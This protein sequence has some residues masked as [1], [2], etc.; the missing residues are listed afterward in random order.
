MAS[1]HSRQSHLVALEGRQIVFCHS[2]E[3]EW[4]HEE[5]GLKCP[6]CSSEATEI[7]EPESD[8]RPV[9]RDLPSSFANAF[10]N[11]NRPPGIDSD[12]DPEEGDIEEHAIGGPGGLFLRAAA[13]RP[14][15]NANRSPEDDIMRRFTELL[16]DLGGP[17]PGYGD[18]AGRSPRTGNRPGQVLFTTPPRIHRTTFHA[19]PVSGTSFTITTGTTHTAG[20]PEG[21]APPD[22]AA[23]FGNLIRPPSPNANDPSRNTPG[24][25]PPF[26]GVFGM[27]FAEIIA[28]LINPQQA[29]RGDAVYTQE[30]LDR[31]ITTLMEANPQS[32]AAPPA[33]QDAIENLEKKRL[34]DEMLGPEGKAECTICIDDMYKGAEVS[35]LPCKHWFHGE[36][37]TLW[38]KEHNTCPICRTPI[39][40]G[41]SRSANNTQGSQ[42][43]PQPTPPQNIFASSPFSQSRPHPPPERPGR[44]HRENEERLNAIR[45]LSGYRRSDAETRPGV[46]RRDSLSPTN[47]R[48]PSASEDASRSARVRSPS[49]R[50]RDPP[51]P[52]YETRPE[53]DGRNYATSSWFGG[54]NS[55]NN[56]SSPDRRGSDGRESRDNQQGASHGPLGWIRDHLTRSSGSGADR[57]RRR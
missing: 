2:C 56:Q 39:E 16:G 34:D 6:R 28:S 5:R 45:N 57:D 49:L 23:I 38:L 15:N 4:Y 7:V 36:C 10:S 52:S 20:G 3:N 18:E 11:A 35:V 33:T 50:E 12:S 27:G 32:N 51:I 40:G 47:P 19:G 21:T 1:L 9:T 42:Q 14:R 41:P 46:S 24:G 25:P 22:F 8:P 44:S 29:V 54:G 26:P 55:G 48:T 13:S 30:A 31:I 37:V 17:R 43:Q 53:Y